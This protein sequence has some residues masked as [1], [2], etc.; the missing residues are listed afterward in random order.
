MASKKKNQEKKEKTENIVLKKK[1]FPYLTVYV[2][3]IVIAGFVFYDTRQGNANKSVI[4]K[5][6]KD[7]HACEY[8]HLAM[9]KIKNG[10]NWSSEKIEEQFPGL[11]QQ[12]V[13]FSEPYVRLSINLVKIGRNFMYNL[14]EAA[15]EKYPIIIESIETYLPGLIE[16]SQKAA[17]NV[18]STSVLYVNRSFDF[19]KNEVFVGQLSPEYMQK[20]ILEAL[21]TT[22]YK[23]VECYHWIYNKVQTS[24]E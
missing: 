17:T 10:L 1:G 21:N 3:T 20:V 2:L 18:Y 13:I 14:K 6:L 7:Y 9:D 11:Q 19:L 4:I 12:I 5:V 8:S 23:A 24:I 22:Q 15:L 16:S